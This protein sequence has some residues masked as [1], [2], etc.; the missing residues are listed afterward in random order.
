MECYVHP[1]IDYLNVKEIVNKQRK[2]IL[3]RLNENS[4]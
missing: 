1:A 4:K 2:F 3:D